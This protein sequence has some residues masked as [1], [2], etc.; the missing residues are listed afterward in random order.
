MVGAHGFSLLASDGDEMSGDDECTLLTMTTAQ[1]TGTTKSGTSSMKKELEWWQSIKWRKSRQQSKDSIPHSNSY[2]YEP[3]EVSPRGKDAWE[4]G[5]PLR[6]IGRR[7]LKRR[8][9]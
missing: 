1:H 5:F 3:V 6:M 7:A 8:F 2:L 9:H 4:F